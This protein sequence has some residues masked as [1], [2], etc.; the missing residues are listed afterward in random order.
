M[1]V[2]RGGGRGSPREGGGTS[3]LSVREVGR[4]LQSYMPPAGD[5]EQCTTCPT[6]SDGRVL[7][8]VGRAVVI[9]SIFHSFIHSVSKCLLSTC[10]EPGKKVAARQQVCSDADRAES[11]E[12][13]W[14]TI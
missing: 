2:R 9:P 3:G 1:T 7:G 5:L 8:C 14:G 12:L 11:R 13:E 10:Y 6:M 4:K